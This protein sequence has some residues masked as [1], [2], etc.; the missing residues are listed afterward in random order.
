MRASPTR[1]MRHAAGASANV[2]LTCGM[3]RFMVTNS[4]PKAD[5]TVGVRMTSQEKAQLAE[6]AAAEGVTLS[7]LL[8]R[9]AFNRPDASRHWGNKPKETVDNEIE[10]LSL[11]G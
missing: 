3:V 11:T 5:A 10:G 8:W 1:N 7:T 4:R 2:Y 6:E 9:R